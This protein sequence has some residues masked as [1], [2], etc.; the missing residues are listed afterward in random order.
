MV[1]YYESVGLCMVLRKLGDRCPISGSGF[2]DT[3]TELKNLGKMCNL[4][5]LICGMSLQCSLIIIKATT[6]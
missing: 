1:R 2:S 5:F 3:T 4:F 6:L